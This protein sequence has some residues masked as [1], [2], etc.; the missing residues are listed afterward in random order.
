MFLIRYHACTT[1]RRA[2]A[3][4]QASREFESV[5]E[6][7]VKGVFKLLNKTALLSRGNYDIR[8]SQ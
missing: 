8:K 4:L 5:L 7:T 6:Q 2:S 3:Y 1:F